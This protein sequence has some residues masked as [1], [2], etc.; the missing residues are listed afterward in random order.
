MKLNKS[1]RHTAYIIML[2]EAKKVKTGKE[3]FNE[4][5]Y[6]DGSCN[7][8]GLC[9]LLETIL[10][11]KN[12]NI[13]CDY[14]LS[15]LLSKKPKTFERYWFDTDSDGWQQRIELLKQCIIETY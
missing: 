7:V 15:E 4:Y 10:N 3:T 11:H 1:Q 2:A 13:L 5:K 8:G 9:D 6:L 14:G 12:I